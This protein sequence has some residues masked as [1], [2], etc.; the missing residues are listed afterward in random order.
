[1]FQK[2]KESPSTVAISHGT[3]TQHVSFQTFQSEAAPG[4]L[5]F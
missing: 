3:R 4:N 1:M 2:S 5:G